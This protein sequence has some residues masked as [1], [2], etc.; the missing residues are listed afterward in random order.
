MSLILLRENLRFHE[1]SREI[2]LIRVTQKGLIKQVVQHHAQQNYT[3]NVV[4]G[5]PPE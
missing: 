3:R 5:E 2:L 4:E 1:N